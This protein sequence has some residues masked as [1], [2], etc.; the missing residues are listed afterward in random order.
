[1]G[2]ISYVLQLIKNSPNLSKLEI[3][4]RATS[5][6]A[7]DALKYLGTPSCLERPLNK[8]EHVTIKIFKS[9]KVKLLFVK[10]LL[11]HTPS[12]LSMHIYQYTSIDTNIALELNRFRRASPLAELFYSQPNS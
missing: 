5:D 12:L 4:V 8:L 1:M 7:K 11:S 9:S 10:L 6:D 2:P 3:W